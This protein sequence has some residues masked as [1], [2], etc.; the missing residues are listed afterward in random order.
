MP[1]STHPCEFLHEYG[2]EDRSAGTVQRYFSIPHKNYSFPS[3]RPSKTLRSVSSNTAFSCSYLSSSP[4]GMD[5]LPHPVHFAMVLSFLEHFS[6]IL[7]LVVLSH[8]RWTLD[9]ISIFEALQSTM[10]SCTSRQT[11]YTISTWP[12]YGSIYDRLDIWAIGAHD[13]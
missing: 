8:V 3:H 10:A 6:K 11:A 9:D 2:E 12:R 1:F 5:L 13:F 4:T 7:A